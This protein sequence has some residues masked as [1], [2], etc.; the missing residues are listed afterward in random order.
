MYHFEKVFVSQSWFRISPMS[1]LIQIVFF[2]ISP[3]AYASPSFRQAYMAF[4]H[5]CVI[6]QKRY[7]IIVGVLNPTPASKNSTSYFDAAAENLHTALKNGASLPLQQKYHLPGTVIF[8]VTPSGKNN[9]LFPSITYPC[10]SQS[11]P[12]GNR[13]PRWLSRHSLQSTIKVIIVLSKSQE[14]AGSGNCQRMVSDFE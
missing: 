3:G 11:R 14:Y 8:G 4:F 10:A 2:F 9:S 7:F 13:D 1:P 5:S 12:S 6:R